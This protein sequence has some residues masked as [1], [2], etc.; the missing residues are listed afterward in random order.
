MQDDQDI[1][2]IA[3]AQAMPLCGK[4]WTA[5]VSL[6]LQLV[7]LIVLLATALYFYAQYWLVPTVVFVVLAAWLGYRWALLRSVRLYYDDIGVWLYSGILPWKRGLTGVKWRDLDEAIFVN[8][9]WS[10]LSRSY[11]VRVRHRFTKANEIDVDNMAQGK[12]AATTINQ[13]HRQRIRDSAP[14]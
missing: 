8:G 5:Y 1:A 2:G 9:F 10:W 14:L 6:A 4:S 12:Q 11:T 7:V 13:Q 3:P